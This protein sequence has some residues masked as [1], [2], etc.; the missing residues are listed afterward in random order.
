VP[1]AT[2]RLE[3]ASYIARQKALRVPRETWYWLP[4]CG[5][6]LIAALIFLNDWHDEEDLGTEGDVPRV[7]P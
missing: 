6:R 1:E 5:R 7:G 2:L 3:T 4:P